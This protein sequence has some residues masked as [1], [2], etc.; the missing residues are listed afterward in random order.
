ME[1][2]VAACQPCN[3]L[4][5]QREYHSFE[6]AK[7][8]VLAKREEWRQRFHAQVKGAGVGAAAH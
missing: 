8:H 4:K 6:D 2:L 3:L 5:G 1:N 7:K